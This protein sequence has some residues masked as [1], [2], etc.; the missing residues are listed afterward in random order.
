MTEYILPEA[1][2]GRRAGLVIAHPG[3]ELQ[4]HGW[5][6]LARP[7]VC[8]LTDG[9]GHTR[10]SR[11]DSTTRLLTQT[12]AKPGAIYGRFADVEIY[13]AI[14]E[15][16]SDF[17]IRLAEELAEVLVRDDIQYVVGDPT[18]GYNPTHDI[19]RSVIDAAVEIA[20]KTTRKRIENFDFMIVGEPKRY[21]D[22]VPDGQVSVHLDEDAMHRKLAAANSYTELSSYVRSL[23]DEF[24][25]AVLQIESLRSVNSSGSA[26]LFKKPPYYERYG[27][28]QVAAGVY[29]RVIRYNEHV[30]PISA[31]LMDYA[32]R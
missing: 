4:V 28:K 26:S 32:H 1:L 19:C 2:G 10:Q 21:L 22:Q 15:K 12:G 17:F 20:Q 29:G 7:I 24:G 13:A 30:L 23:I 14:L 5:M 31:A 16:D 6:E 3:H 27:E 8:V 11:L 25:T 9:S 18:E